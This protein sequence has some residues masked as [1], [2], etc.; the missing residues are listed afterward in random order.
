[1]ISLPERLQ[2]CVEV[3]ACDRTPYMKRPALDFFI[4]I[5]Y[6]TIMCLDIKY[7]HVYFF[8]TMKKKFRQIIN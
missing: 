3:C 8:E 5:L 7:T 2:A 1:M 4:N 6:K